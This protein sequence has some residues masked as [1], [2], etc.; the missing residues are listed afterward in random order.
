MEISSSDL[1]RSI[2]LFILF[3][4]LFAESRLVEE[5]EHRTNQDAAEQKEQQKEKGGNDNSKAEGQN[6]SR[7]TIRNACRDE[8]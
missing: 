8:G 4:C 5:T 7:R 3:V 6:R 1:F 2:Y